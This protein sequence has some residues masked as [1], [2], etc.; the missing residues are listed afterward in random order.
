MY[1]APS[2]DLSCSYAITT[3]EVG[4]LA[5]WGLLVEW[6]TSVQGQHIPWTQRRYERFSF[7]HL[8]NQLKL[9]LGD[10]DNLLD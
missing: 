2:W 7:Q 3:L 6:I 4:P 10:N 9:I 5:W 8:T 1:K